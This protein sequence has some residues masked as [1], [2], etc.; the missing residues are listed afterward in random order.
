MEYEL[1]WG[2]N[3]WIAALVVSGIIGVIIL[4]S[5]YWGVGEAW[6]NMYYVPLLGYYVMLSICQSHYFKVDPEPSWNGL[7]RQWVSITGAVFIFY[8]H[9]WIMNDIIGIQDSLIMSSQFMFIILGFFF[10]GMDD[11]MFKGQLSKWLK[12]DSQ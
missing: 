5:S 1:R 9:E 2:N 6:H 10:F 11:F 12:N 7:S 4:L 3:T 8:V